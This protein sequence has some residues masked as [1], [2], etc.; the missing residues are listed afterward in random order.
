MAATRPHR[1]L[2]KHF[3]EPGD[4][5]ALTFS[6]YQRR[7]LLTNDTWRQELAR[8]IDAAGNEHDIQLAAFVFMPEHVHLLVVPTT[9]EPAID[10]YLARI[11]QP[12]SKWVRQRLVEMKSSLIKQLVV[13]ERPGKTCFR[14]WQEGP[15]YDRNLTTP[16]ADR[17]SDQLHSH[18]PRST[19]PG[20]TGDRLEM[21]E[22][23][24]VPTRPAPTT[25]TDAA[26]H[27]W[28]AG[29]HTRSNL[30]TQR[31]GIASGTHTR[32]VVGQPF[33]A[34]PRPIGCHWLR[35]CSERPKA[36]T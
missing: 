14:F 6:C 8:C 12:F 1:K 4:L 24:L 33:N 30:N 17:S 16:T 18:E 22:C 27:S 21:V 25:I 15:G 7:P 5:H 11:K 26:V 35:Q 29:R 2:V 28:L 13:D 23:K 34:N 32:H 3:H 31:T 10:R 36:C 20:E 19:W 9:N